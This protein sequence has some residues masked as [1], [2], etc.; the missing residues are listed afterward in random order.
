MPVPEIKHAIHDAE[1]RIQ[2]VRGEQH[3]DAA[4]LLD[5]PDQRDDRLLEMRIEADQRLVEQQ[6]PWLA[7]QRLR[8]QQ[9]LEFAA[10]K[11]AQAPASERSARRR[12]RAPGPPPAGRREPISGKPQRSPCQGAGH[13][14][15]AAQRKVRD[16]GALLRQIA[17]GAI[18]APRLCPE[19]PDLAGDRRQQTRGWRC[20]NVVLPAPFGPKTAD[21]LAGPYRRADI[22]E[23]GARRRGRPSPGRARSRTRSSEPSAR[24]S[25]F[26]LRQHPLLVILPWRLGLGHADHGHAGLRRDVLA[27][28]GSAPG[29][30]GCYRARP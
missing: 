8:Q 29:W 2:V 28:A 16:G 24:S 6:Q 21:E 19:D 20:S 17:G 11:F 12:F 4:V 26:E 14:I 25:A 22:G 9:P 13:E 5:L 30:S 27:S 15:P 3:G 18:A 1:Q 7:E 23:D 10:R